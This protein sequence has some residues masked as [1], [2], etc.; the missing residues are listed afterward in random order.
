[1]ASVEIKTA[2]NGFIVFFGN[3]AGDES[4][5]LY[6]DWRKALPEIEDHLEVE[7]AG[8]FHE[9]EVKDAE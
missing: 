1:M 4:L 7:Q 8:V 9:K 6:T 2:D 5:M 3:D